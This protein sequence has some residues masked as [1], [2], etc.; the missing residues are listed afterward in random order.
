MLISLIDFNPVKVPENNGG[1]ASGYYGQ[2]DY[3]GYNQ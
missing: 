3:S 2:Q 1:D